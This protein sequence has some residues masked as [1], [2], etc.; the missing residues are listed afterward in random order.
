MSILSAQDNPPGRV[1]PEFRTQ[2][3][4]KAVEEYQ[5]QLLQVDQDALLKKQE[6]FSL[7]QKRLTE[8]MVN[9]LA[10]KNLQEVEAISS[11]LNVK[12]DNVAGKMPPKQV[13]ELFKQ[14]VGNWSGKFGTTGNSF[15][16]RITEMEITCEDNAKLTPV[17]K[18]GRIVLFG[19]P[20]ENFELIR[21]NDR[22]ILLAWGTREGLDPWKDQPNHVSILTRGKLK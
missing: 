11:F 21:N 8:I 6:L 4:N 3:A 2:E 5:G 1:I 18:E 13:K 17:M 10:K 9:E 15:Q 14:L 16:L 19:H 7:L 12:E 20:T 22:L